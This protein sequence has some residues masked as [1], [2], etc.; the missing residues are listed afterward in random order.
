VPRDRDFEAEPGGGS[1]AP[2]PRPEEGSHEALEG[3]S[4]LDDERLR[5]DALL[6][7]LLVRHHATDDLGQW[8]SEVADVT[9]SLIPILEDRQAFPE[10][11]KAWRMVAFV[12]GI[13]CEWEAVAEAEQHAIR[14]ARLAGNARQEARFAAAYSVAL[15]AGPTRVAEAI[16]RCTEI[17][18]RGLNDRQSEAVVRCSLALLHAM[19]GEFDRARELYRAARPMLEDYGA[20]VAAAWTGSGSA[21]DHRREVGEVG[22]AI[23]PGD[24]VL[25]GGDAHR[26]RLSRGQFGQSL[27]GLV[28]H[29]GTLAERKADEMPALV[30]IG[31]EHLVG[32]RHHSAATR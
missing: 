20:V 7:R 32:N 16:E 23:A 11:A 2:R 31:V 3:A 9:A 26:R 17:L 21:S 8:R 12:H 5:A 19:R 18:D 27:G 22:L 25:D 28:E 10:L 29:L 24:V 4:K 13:T 14:Y 1:A 15:C 30:P 6:T